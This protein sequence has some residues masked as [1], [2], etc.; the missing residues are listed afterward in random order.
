MEKT[1]ESAIDLMVRVFENTNR[2]MAAMSG[3]S[4]EDIDKSISEAHA[5][6]VYY[7]STVFDKL[8]DND[9]IKLN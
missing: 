7:M 2:Q 6:M 9:F 8:E 3:M 1:R 4:E 5:G